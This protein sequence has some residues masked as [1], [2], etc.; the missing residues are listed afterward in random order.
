[1]PYSLGW[2]STQNKLSQVRVLHTDKTKNSPGVGLLVHLFVSVMGAA[3]DDFDHLS[4]DA[5]DDAIRVIDPTAPVAGQIAAEAFRLTDAFI[6]VAVDVFQKLQ[7]T[8]EHLAVLCR[9]VLKIF[10]CFLRP[11]LNH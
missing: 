5:V 8:F 7:D 1:M 6:A 11:C 9:P 2:Q 4:V 10:P 3:L